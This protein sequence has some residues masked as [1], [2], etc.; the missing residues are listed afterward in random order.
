MGCYCRCSGRFGQ[1]GGCPDSVL[2][3]GTGGGAANEHLIMCS[4]LH[5]SV[6][7]QEFLSYPTLVRANRIVA[8]RA[9]WGREGCSDRLRLRLPEAPLALTTNPRRHSST[10]I[11]ALPTSTRARA[12]LFLSRVKSP[13]YRWLRCGVIN[14]NS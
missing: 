13:M 9:A 2:N 8:C 6:Q 11:S 3:T 5:A 7:H 4:G 10:Q 1:R 12:I 14:S